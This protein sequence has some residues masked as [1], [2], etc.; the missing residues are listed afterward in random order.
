MHQAEEL[1]G[2]LPALICAVILA[3]LALTGVAY[4]Q[5]SCAPPDSM[6]SRFTGTPDVA[7]LNELGYW[8]GEQKDYNCAVQAFAT[9]LQLDSKQKQFPAIAFMLGANLYLSGD[10]NEAIAALLEA[11]KNGYNDIKIHLLLGQALDQTRSRT[12]A[13]IEWRAALEIDPEHF[14]ALDN[15]SNDLIAD[16]NDKAVIELLDTPR[17]APLRTAQQDENLGTAY[18]RSGKLDT[19]LHVLQDALNTY[20]DSMPIAEQLAGVLTQ[21]GRKEEAET[22]LSIARA[23]QSERTEAGH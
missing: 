15:L 21:V 6:K 23:R 5:T 4:A 14:V 13:E 9:S 10:T 3:M 17:L 12:D 19:A 18:A 16:E 1:R 8:F 22:V 20:P 2:R 7:A 11:E